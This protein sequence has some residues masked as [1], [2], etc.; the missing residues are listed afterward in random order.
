M[1]TPDVTISPVSVEEFAARLRVDP[2][3]DDE[4]DELIDAVTILDGL[5]GMLETWLGRPTT[6][7]SF[8]EERPHN[9][10]DLYLR[11]T[12][13]AEVATLTVDGY[14]VDLTSGT[15]DPVGL[16]GNYV[17]SVPAGQLAITYT[18]GFAEGSSESNGVRMALLRSARREWERITDDATSAKNLRVE[19]YGVSYITETF[20]ETELDNLKRLKRRRIRTGRTETARPRGRMLV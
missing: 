9:G 4:T 10:G 19:G 12:P 3:W 7:R 2:V 6:V 11:H 16:H 18:A 20:T 17:E 8:T 1:P 14:D 13:L 5:T 15:A